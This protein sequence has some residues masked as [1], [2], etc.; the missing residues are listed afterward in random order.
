MQPRGGPST[1]INHYL[2]RFFMPTS[3]FPIFGIH[4]VHLH[5]FSEFAPLPTP[6]EHRK[7]P[8]I[9]SFRIILSVCERQAPYTSTS[10]PNQL[11]PVAPPVVT[12]NPAPG[13]AS[14][15]QLEAWPHFRSTQ[16]NTSHRLATLTV[17]LR[18]RGPSHASHLGSVQ[19]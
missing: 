1:C 7:L 3:T 4:S 13:P 16:N 9:G 14:F 11:Q 15:P 8:P 18:G 5:R 6:R 2:H 17:A 19:F 12:L 10:T